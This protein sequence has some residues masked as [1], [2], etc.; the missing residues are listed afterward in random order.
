MAI[1]AI[2]ELQ[3][4]RMVEID[5][6][7]ADALGQAQAYVSDISSR[8]FWYEFTPYEVG[9]DEIGGGSSRSFGARRGRM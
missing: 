8:F 1:Q 9:C 5:S 4:E 6:E 7:R 3:S 2:R